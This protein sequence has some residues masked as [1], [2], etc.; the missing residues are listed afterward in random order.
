MLDLV[1]HFH[2]LTK[3][4]N[5]RIYFMKIQLIAVALSFSL[6]ACSS[7]QLNEKLTTSAPEK[8]QGAIAV[9]AQ[10]TDIITLEQVMADPDW[11][12]RAP[13]SWYWGDDSNTVFYKQKQLGNPLRDLYAMDASGN[14]VKQVALSEQH[15]VADSNGVMNASRTHKTYIFNGDVFLKDIASTVVKQLTF[16]SSH[17][18]NAL[19][20]TN[21]DVA[22]Q[23]GNA[24]YVHNFASGQIKELASLKMSDKPA[25]VVAPKSY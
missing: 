19:F 13:E 24:F 25:G 8:V 12:G 2:S 11:F 3:E 5:K 18:R 10:A 20:L 15:K 1:V 4:L 17:E 7:Q 23:V 9:N 21:G 16:T 14:N 6:A 22:Y